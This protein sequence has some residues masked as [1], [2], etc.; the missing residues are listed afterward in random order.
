MIYIIMIVIIFSI[1]FLIRNQSVL[2]FRLK[3][4]EKIRHK[5][6]DIGNYETAINA[7]HDIDKISYDKML[8]QFWKPLKIKNFYK[9]Y[10]LLMALETEILKLKQQKELK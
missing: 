2:N 10:P 3:L 4:L 9:S 5:Y 6:S 1:L 8:F 7:L